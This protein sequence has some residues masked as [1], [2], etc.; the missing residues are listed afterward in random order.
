MEKF[1]PKCRNTSRI[2][3]ISII[4]K[5]VINRHPGKKPVFEYARNYYDF[6]G[7]GTGAK[8]AVHEPLRAG[9]GTR[10]YNQSGYKTLVWVF[11]N[12]K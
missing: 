8:R 12:L 10:P 6:V 5:M 7:A 9:T 11:Y 1:A 3:I 4:N 2:S